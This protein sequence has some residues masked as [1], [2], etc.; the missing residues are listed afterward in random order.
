MMPSE[1]VLMS[2]SQGQEDH[3]SLKLGQTDSGGHSNKQVNQHVAIEGRGGGVVVWCVY[4]EIITFPD[5][6][7]HKSFLCYSPGNI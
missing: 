3:Y 2:I 6:Y 1:L 4:Y 5:N 7:V